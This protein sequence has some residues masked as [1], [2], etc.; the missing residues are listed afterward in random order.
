MPFSPYDPDKSVHR[1]HLNL[2]HW[3]QWGRKYFIT[4]RLADSVPAH[5]RDHWREQRESWFAQRGLSPYSILD[6]LPEDLRNA[7]HREFTTRFHELLDAGHGACILARKEIASI[8]SD[9]L[10]EGHG[11]LYQLEGWVIM[12]NHFHALVEPFK[13]IPWAPSLSD[14]RE[15]VPAGSTKFSDALEV[16]GRRNRS[17]T[18]CVARPNS[19]I[20]ADILPQI[21]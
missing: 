21:P 5:V 10:T 13:N 1:H 16:F 11:D 4:S 2:P 14:G 12:P 6:D 7:F 9:L 15:Q 17:I 3:R 8:L 20:S 19:N 18:S